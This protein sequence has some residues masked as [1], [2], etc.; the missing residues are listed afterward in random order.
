MKRDERR[1]SL[2]QAEDRFLASPSQG[3]PGPLQAITG[4][5]GALP[6]MVLVPLNDALELEAW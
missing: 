6:M 3:W 4:F 5:S 1:G 2:I